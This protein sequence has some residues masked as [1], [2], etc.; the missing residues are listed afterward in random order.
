MSA[1]KQTQPNLIETLA[2]EDLDYAATLYNEGL[3]IP[4][5]RARSAHLEEVAELLGDFAVYEALA[6]KVEKDRAI[7]EVNVEKIRTRRANEA[8]ANVESQGFAEIAPQFSEQ[9]QDDSRSSR[10]RF[11]HTYAS[12][13]ISQEESK[14]AT[15][16]EGLQELHSFL[17]LFLRETK[18]SDGTF[19]YPDMAV[20]AQSILENLT[21]IGEK[22]YQ[23]ATRGIA[24]H[25]KMYLDQNPERQICVLA[26]ISNSEKYPGIR[27]S[28][29]YLVDRILQTFSDDELKE[30]SGRIVS[31]LDDV[32][33]SPENTRLI[34]IDDWSISGTQIRRMYK[35]LSKD[36][37]FSEYIEAN[38]VEANFVVASEERINDG[39]LVETE[40]GDKETL[41]V[42]AYY[43]SHHAENATQEH[44]GHVTG[45]YSSVN[46]DFQKPVNKGMVKILSR[47]NKMRNHQPLITLANVIRPYRT[48][49]P[50]IYVTKDQLTRVKNI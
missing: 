33:V 30:Y 37:R 42:R 50:S 29:A 26:N 43:R 9:V 14:E 31:K 4:D 32:S 25:W 8:A 48:E 46:Y 15:E 12:H 2:P 44:K 24:T 35:E 49:S 19:A 28:D 38:S 1:T 7:A 20:Q 17:N 21:F 22:E 16:K 10:F 3:N 27:K 47:M 5:E 18:G 36:S 41:Q 11:G 13:E 34:L 45:L 6:S 40:L 23:A 39:L